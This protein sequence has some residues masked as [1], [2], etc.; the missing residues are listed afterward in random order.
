MVVQKIL[1]RQEVEQLTG[2]RRSAIYADMAAGRFPKPI[3]V[4]ER[5]VGWLESDIA[6]WQQARIAAGYVSQGSKKPE[7]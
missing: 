1:R 6:A 7:R 3:R 2:R 5:A 4:G